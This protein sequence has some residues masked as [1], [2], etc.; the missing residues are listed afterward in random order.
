MRP[1]SAV[2]VVFGFEFSSV[3]AAKAIN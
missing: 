1:D 3:T 2:H